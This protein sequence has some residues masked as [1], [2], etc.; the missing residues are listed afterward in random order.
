M[1]R[2]VIGIYQVFFLI[3][4]GYGQDFH[5]GINALKTDRE[6]AEKW[7]ELGE[8]YFFKPRYDSAL[9]CYNSGFPYAVKSGDQLLAGRF[10][11]GKS[12]VST[13]L[14]R[15]RETL[16][17]ARQAEPYVMATREYQ[18][19]FG[20][21]MHR[22]NGH[23]F[24][25]QKDSALYFYHQAE[26]LN[27]A[28]K[29][30]EN[31]RV[32]LAM[33]QLYSEADNFNAAE[34]YFKKAHKM[35]AGSGK[36]DH[37]YVLMLFINMYNTWGKKAETE[38]LRK[39]YTAFQAEQKRLN[40]VDPIS[41]ILTALAGED[42]FEP[43]NGPFNGSDLDKI[44]AN[45]R[46]IDK[47]EKA[48][49][50]EEA[51]QLSRENERL[52][53][54][55]ENPG[56]R[57][58]SVRRSF[59]LLK[60]LQRDREAAALADTLIVLRDTV[61]EKQRR[62][63]LYEIQAKFDTERKQKEIELLTSRQLLSDREIEVL[64]SQNALKEKTIAL[65]SAD[66]ELSSLKLHQELTGREALERENRLMD[67]IVHKEKNYSLSLIRE[68]EMDKKLNALLE[69][70][71]KKREAELKRE[72]RL[73]VILTAGGGLLLLSGLVIGLMY[74]KQRVKSR[75]IQQQ[76]DDLEILMKEIHHRVKNNMQIV[77]SLLDLQSLSI[78]DLQAAEAVKEG[79]N[80]VQSMALIHQNLYTENN[81]KGIR[82]AP[83]ISQLLQNLCNS[84]NSNRDEIN[85][86]TD[87]EDLNLDIDTMIPL[88]LILNE[89]LTN[90]FKYGLRENH[91]G[92]LEITLRRNGDALLLRVKDNGPGFPAGIDFRTSPSFG[93]KMIRAFAQKLKATLDM[94]NEE[95]AL[96]EL[97]I[98]KFALT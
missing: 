46:M 73:R 96:V 91:A 76:A 71:N 21:Y 63:Q 89:M 56:Y 57:Y 92:K 81:L 61:L 14:G 83:Y 67:S 70:E 84:Y 35:T 64:N 86:S 9:Y 75:I 50:L 74:R 79:K 93:L 6:R 65:L 80:R 82:T 51:L 24:L 68:K 8:R 31:W 34:L 88:G 19:L 41:G 20:Y 77:S 32:Y 66:K 30:N 72:K 3:R 45:S 2:L 7:L 58:Y 52:S 33:G 29:P 13:M 38:Q 87:I 47:L 36:A 48:G 12:A 22:A 4:T 5:A 98:Q 15:F 43:K 39:E 17:Y 55:L 26:L 16:Y 37:G 1:R 78:V 44:L 42:G 60:L 94:R 59:S 62:D 23:N 90:S 95:G 28:E 25:Q 53:V 49:R 85:I 69:G 11:M 10:L 40:S 97:C 54:R 27:N 18:L